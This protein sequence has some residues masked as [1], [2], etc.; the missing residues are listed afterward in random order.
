M[1]SRITGLAVAALATTALAVAA[2]PALGGDGQ[3]VK[4]KSEITMQVLGPEPIFFGGR[5]KADK[6]ACKRDRKVKLFSQKPGEDR[7]LEN[8]KT[9][10]GSG[11]W[12][13]RADS[14]RGPL[15]YFAV[16][17]REKQRGYICLRD[18][19]PVLTH[20]ES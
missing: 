10:R 17:T 5:V 19:L 3:K 2:S 11:H 1:A 15:H 18:K 9:T 13:A 20:G 6:A 7:R 16:V 14:H 8:T 4:L 12:A